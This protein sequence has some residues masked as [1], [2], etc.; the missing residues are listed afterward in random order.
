MFDLDAIFSDGCGNDFSI[1]YTLSCRF[2]GL[3]V[4]DTTSD[5]AS[6]NLF[7]VM[8]YVSL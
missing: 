5:L 8:L 6:L 4:L 7:G 2:D 3:V 1:E